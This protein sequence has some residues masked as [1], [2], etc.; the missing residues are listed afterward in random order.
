M[1]PFWASFMRGPD[2]L[3]DQVTSAHAEWIDS[4]GKVDDETDYRLF[5]RYD[6]L[7]ERLRARS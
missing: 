3:E 6:R 2:S 4:A 7:A 1:G 5:L